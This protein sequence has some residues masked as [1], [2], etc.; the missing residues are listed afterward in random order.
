M[1]MRETDIP[2]SIIYHNF[3]GGPVCG[4]RSNNKQHSILLTYNLIQNIN[5]GSN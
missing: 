1:Y 3:Q 2:T 4:F 5:C